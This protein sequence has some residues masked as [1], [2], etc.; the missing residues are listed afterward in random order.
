VPE[1]KTIVGA[2]AAK[3]IGWGYE[4]GMEYWTVANSWGGDWGEKGYF[5]M[6]M[7]ECLLEKNAIVG[8]PELN[9]KEI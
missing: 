9:Y 5:R 3:L 1:N 7:G 6:K 2:H 4:E 8:L